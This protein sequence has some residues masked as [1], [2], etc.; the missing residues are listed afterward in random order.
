[1]KHLFALLTIVTIGI[2]TA[3]AQNSIIAGDKTPSGSISTTVSKTDC[4]VM[5]DK[6]HTAK[7]KK[8]TDAEAKPY[9][10]KMAAMGMATKKPGQLTSKQFM[11]ACEAGAFVGM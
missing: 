4:K 11:K 2:T 8:W 7:G 10:D 5:R 6:A 3:A 9:L 1:M